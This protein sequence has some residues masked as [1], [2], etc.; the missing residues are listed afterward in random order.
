ML[1]HLQR[2]LRLW[3]VGV[4]VV[5]IAILELVTGLPGWWSLIVYGSGL[6]IFGL[7]MLAVLSREGPSMHDR[8]RFRHGNDMHGHY[9]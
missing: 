5:V 3:M 9:R 6:V 4:L 2:Y 1:M 8:S 7:V